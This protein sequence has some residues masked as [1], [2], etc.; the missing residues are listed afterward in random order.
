MTGEILCAALHHPD[1][2]TCLP[3]VVA[4]AVTLLSPAIAQTP[5]ATQEILDNMGADREQILLEHALQEGTVTWY[6]DHTQ[7][8]T[9][10]A[11]FEEKYPG[12]KVEPLRGSNVGLRSATG[13]HGRAAHRRRL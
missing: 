9:L 3:D 1:C 8:E 10:A 4:G 7:F 6:T 2:D 5:Q 12:I 13:V 11:A